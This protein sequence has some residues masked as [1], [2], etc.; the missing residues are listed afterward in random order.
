MTVVLDDITSEEIVEI[1]LRA[2]EWLRSN[3]PE[4]KTAGAGQS[5]A[6]AKIAESTS[7][8]ML[9]GIGF[10]MLI[11]SIILFLMFRSLRYGLIA[12]IP[13][14]LPILIGFGIWGYL[15]GYISLS[16]SIVAAIV[17]GVVVDD[18]VHFLSK[19]QKA[20]SLG[21]STHDA[22]RTTFRL[23]GQALFNTTVIIV[24][25]FLTFGISDF[26]TTWT[27]GY[28]VAIMTSVALIADFLFLPPLLLAVDGQSKHTAD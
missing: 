5:L 15:L 28:A 2:Q 20:R 14:C 8:S 6:S 11:I 16:G 26:E 24:L 13:N 1:D 3:A 23:T 4:M 10:A 21:E 7:I 22:I 17:F 25:G 9:F 19:Y 18:T 27:M 12:L